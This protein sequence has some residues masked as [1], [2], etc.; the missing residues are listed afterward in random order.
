MSGRI[1]LE[2]P[3]KPANRLT[4]AGFALDK[5]CRLMDIALVLLPSAW[6]T[7][8]NIT[9]EDHP[10]KGS[11]T[12][13]LQSV[14]SVFL[15]LCGPVAVHAQLKVF[16]VAGG[17][18]H[19][20]GPATSSYL[21]DPH[22]A[23]YDAAG[24]LYIADYLNHRIRKLLPNGMITTV[25]GTGISGFSGDGGPAR[26]AMI[27]FPTGV[28]VD[29]QG[30]IL[31][32]DDA[33][34]RI[35]RIDRQGIITTVAGNGTA[36]YSGDGGPALDASF[37]FPYC[38]ATDRAGNIYI[39]DQLNNVIRKIDTAGIVSTFAGNGTAGFSG[40]GGPANQ[41]SLNFPYAVLPDNQG[42]LY[43]GDFTNNRVRKVDRNH[44][45]T[46]FAGNG[47]TGCVGDGGPATSAS[48]GGARGMLISGGSLLIATGG[49]GKIRSVDLTTNI[50]GTLAGSSGGYD[51]DG[52]P[53]GLTKFSGP[54]SPLLDGQ[55]NL[56]V[57]DRGNDRVRMLDPGTH[58]FKTIAGGFIG[59]GGPGPQSALNLPLGINFDSAGNLYIADEFDNRVRVVHS[60]G[61]ISTVAGTGISGYTG[62]GGLA[63]N[64]KL[65]GP[66]AVAADR[67]G[68][69]Y[70]AD[71]FG[72]ILRKVSP[73][74][75]I[76]TSPATG[77]FFEL[78]GMAT[79]SAGNLYGADVAACVVWKITPSG[80]VSAV[81]GDA[82]SFQCD[83]NGDNIPAGQALLNF[84][85][86]VDVDAQ[87]NIYIADSSNSRIRKITRS[88][89]IIT[90]IAGNGICGFSGDGGPGTAAMICFPE[91]VAVDQ[92]GNVYL[93]DTSN[94]RVRKV[95][96][97]GTI[98]TVAGTGSFAGYNGN[99][100]PAL[101]TNLDTLFDVAVS[102]AGIVHWSDG[103]EFRVRKA[104]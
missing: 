83:Y 74:G 76:R 90:T 15:A 80:T 79:D 45:I 6:A 65:Y 23:A 70:I 46:T 10:M 103:I 59:D 7:A 12:S 27:S 52:K 62:D 92:N 13:L 102:P 38:V 40:D 47:S 98:Q 51:G 95:D 56:V 58:T 99:G 85:T 39:G 28:W 89:G 63:S 57:V 69:V 87:G 72:G 41:A 16:T 5:T 4:T 31:L 29:G 30:N 49:C 81:A 84:P 55:G 60:D 54:S 35:R 68:N 93:T 101:D 75:L 67:N 20:N 78:N 37:N 73:N 19:D 66:T 53:A 61:T 48:I 71:Q 18:V 8:R 43:I 100:L 97:S 36:G 1:F 50:I 32:T 104:Q 2:F 21:A 14:L 25:A 9:L 86:D 96:S 24:N 42:N 33:N 94:A 82:V 91:G 11:C 34:N 22:L 44:V 64:A 3:S 77:F 26:Q 88:T 17:A